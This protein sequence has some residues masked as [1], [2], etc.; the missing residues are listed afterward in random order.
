M[1]HATVPLLYRTIEYAWTYK[2]IGVVDLIREYG[3]LLASNDIYQ[4]WPGFFATM[5]ILSHVAGVDALAFGPE[6]T[7][8]A[9]VVIDSASP[10]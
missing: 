3:H 2:H 1:M 9:A 6:G 10:P 5:A 4:Q 7:T 8:A